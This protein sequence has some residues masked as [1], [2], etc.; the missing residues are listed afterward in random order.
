MP[1]REAPI[2][3]LGAGFEMQGEPLGL[4]PVPLLGEHTEQVL[5]ALGYES[6]EISALRGSGALG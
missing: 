5:T 6:G 2:T 4:G 3:L 1:G